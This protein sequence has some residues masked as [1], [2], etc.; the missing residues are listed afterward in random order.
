MLTG[1]VN[2]G[3]EGGTERPII[4]IYYTIPKFSINKEAIE[5]HLRGKGMVG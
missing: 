4:T 5:K 1:G 2:F 3:Q